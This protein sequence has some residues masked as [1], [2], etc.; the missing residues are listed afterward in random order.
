MPLTDVA[1]RKFKPRD[2]AYKEA[3]GGGLYV[4]V[5]PNGARSFRW[6]YQF[7][8][9]EKVM[10]FGL[11]PDVK[12]ADA[13]EMHQSARAELR[14]GRDP[15]RR[16]AKRDDG[17]TFEEVARDWHKRQAPRWSVHH[18]ADVLRSLE[19]E[20]FPSIGG[21][22]IAVLGA[23]EMLTALRGVEDRGAIETAHRIRQRAAAVFAFAI[24]AVSPTTTQPRPSRRR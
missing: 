6:K 21:T 8:G 20:V 19:R 17:I 4:F 23:R 1:I 3:D 2:K 22:P 5:T 13:R 12:L 14:K 9:R 16:D 7:E 15:G 18:A 11:Y 10:T 24:P